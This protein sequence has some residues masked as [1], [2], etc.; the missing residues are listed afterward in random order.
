MGQRG[1]IIGY[2]GASE[3]W[4]E[5][6]AFE[7]N[8]RFLGQ[9]SGPMLIDAAVLDDGRIAVMWSEARA[10]RDGLDD[11]LAFY[12]PAQQHLAEAA[13]FDGSPQGPSLHAVPQAGLVVFWPASP[14]RPDAEA[15]YIAN[16]T[17][18]GIPVPLT[19]SADGLHDLAEL[20]DGTIVLLS[21]DTE[22]GTL[23]LADRPSVATLEQL[24]AGRTG[25]AT[26]LLEDGRVLVTGGLTV[27]QQARTLIETGDLI[28]P[29][30][31]LF[32]FAPGNEASSRP[33]KPRLRGSSRSPSLPALP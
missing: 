31:L 25:N 4:T 2:D 13:R 32:T 11:V 8:A 27:T 12:N 15:E 21:I 19:A 1:D 17:S 16:L 3:M 23:T 33:S 7:Q 26:T 6:D 18:G 20:P 29:D 24:P 30:E 5:L 9:S 14:E 28:L 22:A 10:S